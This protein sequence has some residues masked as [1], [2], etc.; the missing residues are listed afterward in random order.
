MHY[1]NHELSQNVVLDVSM[2]ISVTEN[3][4]PK[5]FGF[6]TVGT[7]S[8]PQGMLFPP[9]MKKLAYNF[10]LRK[11]AMNKL[12]SNGPITV[13]AQNPHTH[14][15][16]R[17]LF[18]SVV[19]DNKEMTK[20][21]N[22]KYYNSNYQYNNWLPEPITMDMGDE[23]SLSCVYNT[24]DRSQPTYAGLSTYEEMCFD[25]ILYYPRHDELSQVF[26]VI[27]F[28]QW[29]AFFD[30]LNKTGMIDWK[31][32]DDYQSFFEDSMKSIENSPLNDDPEKLENL[33]QTFIDGSKRTQY[34][35]GQK[36]SERVS[37]VLPKVERLTD[38]S[39]PQTTGST[40]V[41]SKLT[42]GNGAIKMNIESSSLIFVFILSIYFS[43]AL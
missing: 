29:Y 15:A 11:E 14:L 39:C 33:F 7:I 16:G 28:D 32:A 13:V 1:D 36:S 10:H 20:I 8:S 3:Y 37:R 6:L 12:Y 21:A 23:I 43:K 17:Q 31:F 40:T 27:D 30:D 18:S 4:R 24:E 35:P 22:N 26:E 9:K 38:T 42:T 25:F 34:W 19:K 5:E 41:V 2:R